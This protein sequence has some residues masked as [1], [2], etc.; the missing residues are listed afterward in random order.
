MAVILLLLS[1]SHLF[2][3][4]IIL[5]LFADH[6]ICFTYH[7]ESSLVLPPWLLGHTALFID[8]RG[9]K[10]EKTLHAARPIDSTGGLCER[11]PWAPCGTAHRGRAVQ[12]LL[13]A[14]LE[15]QSEPANAAAAS[16]I[17][18]GSGVFLAL[19]QLLLTA[20][21]SLR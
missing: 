14:V 4:Q 15:P 11:L 7:K 18:T 9:Q 2:L 12:V 17:L 20:P 6:H 13:T 3:C 5:R 21:G 19:P 16:L 1:T 8:P 10:P